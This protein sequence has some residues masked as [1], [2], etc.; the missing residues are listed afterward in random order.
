MKKIAIILLAVLMLMTFSACKDEPDATKV[1]PTIT[2]PTANITKCF[3]VP[4]QYD[5]TPYITIE[6]DDYL[7]IEIERVDSTVTDDDLNYA[8][9][10]DLSEHAIYTEVDRGAAMGDHININFTGSVDGIKFDGGAAENYDMVLGQAGFIDDFEE[11]LA[12]HAK[13]EEFVIDVTFPED[14]GKEELNGKDAQFEIKINSVKEESLP[15]FND[16]FVKEYYDCDSVEAYLT[17]LQEELIALKSAD[18]ESELKGN[19]YATIYKN[20]EFKDYPE[21][22]FEFYYNDFVNYYADF[23]KTKGVTLEEFFPML[24][25][26]EEEFYSYA[27]QNAAVSVE[28]ELVCFAIANENK[29]WQSLT[30]GDYDKYLADLAE[31]NGAE[32]AEFE[33]MYTPEAIWKSLILDRTIEYVIENATL[34]DPAPAIELTP[35]PIPE[36]ETAE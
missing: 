33:E 22:E 19:A 24:G 10:E 35:E 20:V 23:A 5:L 13:G 8:I 32:P 11:Q 18:A 31:L 1:D 7:G 36:G 26:N 29:L 2:D 4:Y 30:K 6:K 9:M 21:S 3:A 34:V 17:M 12:G 28:Q 16:A 15:E 27:E 25:T 14:Y